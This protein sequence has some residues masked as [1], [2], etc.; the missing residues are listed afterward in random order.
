MRVKR[1]FALVV[2]VLGVTAL[3]TSQALAGNAIVGS[4]TSAP[5]ISGANPASPSLTGAPFA[6]QQMTAGTIGDV[7]PGPGG[8]GGNGGGYNHCFVSWTPAYACQFDHVT[9]VEIVTEATLGEVGA[10]GR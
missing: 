5:P 2:L 9:S 6:D 8:G 1:L 7:L 3:S 4:T 10:A